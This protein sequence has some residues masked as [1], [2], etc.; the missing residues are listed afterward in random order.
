ML[1]TK[2][3]GCIFENRNW[4][5]IDC[6][7]EKEVFVQDNEDNQVVKGFCKRKRNETWAKNNGFDDIETPN[8]LTNVIKTIDKKRAVNLISQEEDKYSVLISVLDKNKEK[9][10]KT[11]FD[12]Y[13]V[14]PL[15]S[16]IIVGVL[17]PNE[18]FIKHILDSLSGGSI[19]F[20]VEAVI[21]SELDTDEKIHNYLSKFVNSHWFLQLN[22]G[23]SI[24]PKLLTEIC[25]NIHFD[26]GNYLLFFLN[27][28]KY[29]INKFVFNEL[30][31]HGTKNVIEKIKTFDDWKEVCSKIE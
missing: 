14:H 8:V 23:D 22:S 1:T 12:I 29:I 16:E 5:I 9:F 21:D 13:N 3:D 30:G 10:D 11:L 24:D 4:G 28:D 6:L 15:A 26:R 19:K 2:C 31:G 18:D 17:K 7:L 27:D 20:K 25:S